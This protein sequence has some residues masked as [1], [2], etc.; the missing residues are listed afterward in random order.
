MKLVALDV[1]LRGLIFTTRQKLL[2]IS[3]LAFFQT[4]TL[5]KVFKFS[6]FLEGQ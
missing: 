1:C 3:N 2:F 4:D 6:S 5:K